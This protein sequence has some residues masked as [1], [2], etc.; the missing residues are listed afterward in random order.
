M[1]AV[2]YFLV[3]LSISNFS[4][5]NCQSVRTGEFVLKSEEFGDFLITRTEKNQIEYNEKSGIKMK[6]SLKWLDNCKYQLFNSEV[7][8]GDDSLLGNE[9]DTLTV[10]ILE[11][12]KDY[13]KVATTANFSDLSLETTLNIIK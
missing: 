6:Y 7:L 1:K 5:D 8:S 10:T 3:F 11:V 13:Y 9:G 12:G 4:Q 2:F